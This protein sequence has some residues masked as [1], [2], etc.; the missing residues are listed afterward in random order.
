VTRQASQT[1]AAD[2]VIS[3]F[4][5]PTANVDVGSKVDLTVSSGPP[6]P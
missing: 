6:K 3:Q 4:P 2:V 1:F 5:I